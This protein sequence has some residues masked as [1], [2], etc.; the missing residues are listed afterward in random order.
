MKGKR[1]KLFYATQAGIAPPTFVFFAREAGSVH[2]SYRRYLE[3]RLRDVFGFLGTPIRLV[4]RERASV[5]IPRRRGGRANRTDR[6]PAEDVRGPRRRCPGG[7]CP[8]PVSASGA[9]GGPGARRR[10]RQRR[11]GHD[12]RAPRRAQRAGP[13]AEPLARDGGGDRGDAPQRA[14]PARGRAAGAHPVDRRPVGLE[15]AT[16]LVILA[17]PSAHLRA[18]V[19]R[20]GSAHPGVGGRAVGRQGPRERDAPADDRG[21]RGREPR[22]RRPDRPAPDRRALRPEPRPG[23]RQGPAGVGGRSR[24]RTRRSATGSSRGSRGA[25]SGC[26]RTRTSSASSCA[27]PSRTSSPSPPGR[28]T[29][30]ASATT[31]RPG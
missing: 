14:P 24:R 30:S 20:V 6:E 23:D 31:A 16:D 19:E 29:G 17:V 10:R 18:T 9:D 8:Q 2:F 15:A 4:F 5:K 12:A 3:N 1:P 28:R 21:H 27:A 13:A 7:A 26:T 25:S 22:G 11:L